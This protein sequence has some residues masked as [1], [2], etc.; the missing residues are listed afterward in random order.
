MQ[1]TSDLVND[2]TR[3]PGQVIDSVT[4]EVLGSGRKGE[5]KGINIIPL[6]QTKTWVVYE[7]LDGGPEWKAE[8]P[9]TPENAGWEW[10]EVIDGVPLRRDQSLNYYVMLADQV[11]DPTAIPFMI[12]F[13]RTMYRV[14]RAL[15]THFKKCAMAAA[16]G[17][18]VPPAAT[19]FEL[20]VGQQ[21]NDN[22]TWWIYTL[23]NVGKTTADDLSIC[24]HWYDTINAGGTKVDESEN[25]QT[26]NEE[27]V[28]GVVGGDAQAG[29]GA[30]KGGPQ[31]F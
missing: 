14:G 18:P 2:Q 31:K 25:R 1:G 12:S 13:R 11:N 29:S 16:M 21:S 15:D 23:K 10:K 3:E 8:V 4:H 28:E 17:H 5:E 7:D 26:G 22:N 9:F 27:S 6:S 30:A 24:K 19:I 20:G